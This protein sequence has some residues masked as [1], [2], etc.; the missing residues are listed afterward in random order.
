LL[1]ASHPDDDARAIIAARK[2]FPVFKQA[3]ELILASAL[4]ISTELQSV[5]SRSAPSENLSYQQAVFTELQNTLL[6]SLIGDDSAATNLCASIETDFGNLHN[7]NIAS[8]VK[9]SREMNRDEASFALIADLASGIA[10]ADILRWDLRPDLKRLAFDIIEVKEGTVNGA[11]LDLEE[12]F[13]ERP[14]EFQ[15]AMQQFADRYGEKG[16][17]QL[18]RYLRQGE[19]ADRFMELVNR[20]TVHDP[21]FEAQRF[22]VLVPQEESYAE[23][24]NAILADFYAYQRQF[25]FFQIDHLYF[26]FF[27][28]DPDRP[29]SRMDFQHNIYHEVLQHPWAEC[30]YKGEYDK[31]SFDREFGTY[32][33]FTFLDFRENVFLQY[34]R[35]LPLTGLGARYV[36]DILLNRL[37]VFVYLRDDQILRAFREA[38]IDVRLTKQAGGAR[39]DRSLYRID[40]KY[41]EVHLHDAHNTRMLLGAK[42]ILRTVLSL[43]TLRSFIE[44]VKCSDVGGRMGDLP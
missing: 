21:V 20:G 8:V 1:R 15:D 43:Q 6:W 4:E 10:I 27:S 28:V 26:G 12:I 30:C 3:Q 32:V 41:I 5:D 7:R 31:V 24:L 13:H 17:K 23:V 9:V 38:A 42:A 2:H 29:A 35:P 11:I 33:H 19:R 40:G 39:P 37:K 34:L 14:G 22:I 16:R 36:T 18:E 44:H 25:A